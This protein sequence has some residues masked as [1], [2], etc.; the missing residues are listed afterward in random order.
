MVRNRSE[1]A[2]FCIRE[3]TNAGTVKQKYMPCILTPLLRKINHMAKPIVR[4]WSEAKVTQSCLTLYHPMDST[5]HGILQQ[6]RILEWV[7]FPFSKGSSQPRD[8]TQVSCT[9]RWARGKP[10]NTEVGSLSLLQ[11]IFLNQ[12]SNRGLPHYRCIL[13]QLSYLSGMP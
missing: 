11:E 2:K 13:Y 7:A 10:R 6:A 1:Q 9:T 12:E 3:S 4:L 8:Q 5:V